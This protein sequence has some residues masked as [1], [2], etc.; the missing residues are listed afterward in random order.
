[1]S[2][3]ERRAAEE[4]R[5]CNPQLERFIARKFPSFAHHDRAELR[6]D[7]WEALC[8]RRRARGDEGFASPLA[9]LERAA[10]SLGCN[11]RRDRATRRTHP[12]DPN[13]RVFWAVSGGDVAD[14]VIASSDE[15][16]L[17]STLSAIGSEEQAVLFCRII[18][19]LRARDV[20]RILGMTR[21]RYEL[22]HARALKRAKRRVAPRRRKGP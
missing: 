7:A 22:V 12:T 15:E 20:W 11:L 10:L 2:E 5:S 16:R 21:K 3:D 4:Y 13:S 18:L 8:R 1:V 17:L 19:G 14:E 9:Y 6:D